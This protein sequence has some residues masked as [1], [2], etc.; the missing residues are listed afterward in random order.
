MKSG[1][2]RRMVLL[3]AGTLAALFVAAAVLTLLDADRPQDPDGP[4]QDAVDRASVQSP[5]VTLPAGPEPLYRL[6]SYQGL[7]SVFPPEGEQPLQVT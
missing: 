4:P 1:W 7:V 5:E 3:V 2:P 6:A